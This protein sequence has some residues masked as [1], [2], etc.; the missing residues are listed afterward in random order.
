[1]NIL[2]KQNLQRSKETP[3]KGSITTIPDDNHGSDINKTLKK[4]TK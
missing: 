4:T 2:A 1:V 3:P